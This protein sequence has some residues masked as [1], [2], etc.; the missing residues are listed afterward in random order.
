MQHNSVFLIPIKFLCFFL[1]LSP[2]NILNAQ[3]VIYVN[4]KASGAK[5]GTSWTDAFV[6]I[7]DAI[8]NSQI[9]DTIFSSLPSH[10]TVNFPAIV[11]PHWACAAAGWRG[12]FLKLCSSYILQ[13][14]NI[15]KFHIIF[16]LSMCL[17]KWL[18]NRQIAPFDLNSSILFLRIW[19]IKVG[20]VLKMSWQPIYLLIW[21]QNIVHILLD[22]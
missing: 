2:L 13:K 9:G 7:E 14:I 10:S 3:S 19:I 20:F 16:F 12:G 22:A 11:S 1:L 21:Y 8:S 5:D 17:F 18:F 6:K 4:T 15:G